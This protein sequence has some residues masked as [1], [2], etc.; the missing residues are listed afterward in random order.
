MP[1]TR[2]LPSPWDSLAAIVRNSS[3]VSGVVALGN[4]TPAALK[5]STLIAITLGLA[6]N[7]VA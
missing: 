4:G 5:A 6:V 7:G 2:A 3:S 1:K